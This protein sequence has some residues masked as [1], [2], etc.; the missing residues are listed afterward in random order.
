[1]REGAVGSRGLYMGLNH[2]AY[3]C[4]A[5]GRGVAVVSDNEEKN[6]D[7]IRTVATGV[8]WNA[9]VI[10]ESVHGHSNG[11]GCFVDT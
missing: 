4:D 10:D 9:L 1:V 2:L 11:R 7:G 3:I 5:R 6:V 8:A